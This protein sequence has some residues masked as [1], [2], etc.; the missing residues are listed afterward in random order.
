MRWSGELVN[1]NSDLGSLEGDMGA[2]SCIAFWEDL[3][4]QSPLS[5]GE[6][7]A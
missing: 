6:N 4:M 1:Q 2:A 7:G 3:E 5:L